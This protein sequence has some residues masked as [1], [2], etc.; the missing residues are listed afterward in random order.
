MNVMERL[1]KKRILKKDKQRR[2]YYR[3]YTDQQ[4]GE[5]KNYD[6]S[7]DS[8]TLGEDTCVDIICELAKKYFED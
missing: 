6:I 8:G 1:T 5:Y 4:W 2:T 3:Y 7:L